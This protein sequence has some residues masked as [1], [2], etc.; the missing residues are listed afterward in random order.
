MELPN[1]IQNEV[2][3]E[4][5]ELHLSDDFQEEILE[6]NVFSTLDIE[7]ILTIEDQFIHQLYHKYSEQSVDKILILIEG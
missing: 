4:K 7:S 3:Y 6:V 5:I 2:F 1:L